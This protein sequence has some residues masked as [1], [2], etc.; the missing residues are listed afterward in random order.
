VYAIPAGSQPEQVIV[1]TLEV[2]FVTFGADWYITGEPRQVALA[3]RKWPYK[4]I[5]SENK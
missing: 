2:A 3:A 1:Q 5:Q 4:G